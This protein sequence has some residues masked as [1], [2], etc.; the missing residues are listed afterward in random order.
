MKE[1]WDS[2]RSPKSNPATPTAS[3]TNLPSSPIGTPSNAMKLSNVSTRTRDQ[4]HVPNERRPAHSDASRDQ[5]PT[6][7]TRRIH[8][9]SPKHSGKISSFS[10]AADDSRRKLAYASQHSTISASVSAVIPNR[11]PPPLPPRR[12]RS[13]AQSPACSVS[14]QSPRPI[15]RTPTPANR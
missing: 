14:F 15:R 13:K 12:K 7:A 2:A 8:S 4:V 3:G 6:Q 11:Q 10:S 5:G 1:Q 9:L